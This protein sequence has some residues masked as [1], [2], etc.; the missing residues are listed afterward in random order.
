[1]KRVGLVACVV[2]A[3]AFIARIGAVPSDAWQGV[4]TKAQAERG[5]TVYAENCLRCHGENL[6]TG[7]GGTEYGIPSPPLAGRSFLLRWDGRGVDELLTLMRTTMPKN[8]SVRLTPQEYADVVAFLLQEN[9]FPAGSTEL[10]TDPS[11]LSSIRIGLGPAAA[12]GP[13]PPATDEER[14]N[15]Q[16]VEQF[17]AA[18]NARD[19]VR[20]MSFFAEGAR[21][22]VGPIGRA[23][24]RK[25]DFVEFITGA[26]TLKMTVTPGSTW[27]RGPVVVHERTDDIELANGSRAP[28]GTYIGVFTLRD[29]KI[30][31]FID[32]RKP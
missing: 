12:A 27:A 20:V 32:F 5:V 25:P 3:A 26:K 6:E 7:S 28:S 8:S 4:Y 24:F 19:A 15:I 13:T 10:L 17:V 30:V 16:V 14:A 9:G 1:M 11:L 21:F 2:S 31:D 22:A 29:H 23:E 18:W